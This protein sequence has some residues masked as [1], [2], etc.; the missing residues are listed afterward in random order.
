LKATLC[1]RRS[2]AHE[3]FVSQRHEARQPRRLHVLAPKLSGKDQKFSDLLE[4]GAE[5]APTSTEPGRSTKPGGTGLGLAISHLLARQLG[6]ELALA[7][8]SS[9]GTKFQL[10]LPL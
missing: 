4:A 3:Y 7:S 9:A 8:S 5:E 6:G 10:R 1:A 2:H